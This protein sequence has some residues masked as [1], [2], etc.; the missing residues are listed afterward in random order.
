MRRKSN[1]RY[2]KRQARPNI[3]FSSRSVT[4]EK[5]K[6]HFRINFSKIFKLQ[7]TLERVLQIIQNQFNVLPVINDEENS[8]HCRNLRCKR[9]NGIKQRHK[10]APDAIKIDNLK[11]AIAKHFQAIEKQKTQ[12]NSRNFVA[13]YPETHQPP[14]QFLMTKKIL[15]SRVALGIE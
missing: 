5:K 3:F 9:R 6:N 13:C 11:D 2:E 14:S 1:E 12:L 10:I 4:V 7:T 8:C 15:F